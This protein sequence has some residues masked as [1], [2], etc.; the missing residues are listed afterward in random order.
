MPKDFHLAD[1]NWGELRELFQELEFTKWLKELDSSD[2]LLVEEPKSAEVEQQYETVLTL[3][4]WSSWL[5]QLQD[6]AVFAFDTETTSIDPME[7]E[8][9]GFSVS[10]QA[11]ERPYVPLAHDYPDAPQQCNRE[12]VLQ[13]LAGILNDANKTCVGHNLKY[14]LHV[15]RHQEIPVANRL[16]DTMLASYIINPSARGHKLDN[17]VQSAFGHTMVAFEDVAG[18]GAKQVTFDQVDLNVA[19][20]YAAE[21]A[22]MT[23]RLYHH[24]CPLIEAKPNHRLFHEVDLPLMQVLLNMEH[25]GVNIDAGMLVQQSNELANKLDHL[26]KEI[27]ESAEEEF[28]V[29][30]TKQLRAVLFDKLQLPIIKKTP[31][32]QP[33]TSEEVLQELALT[34]VLP[35]KILEFRSSQK[36][37]S[38][39]TDKLPLQIN[40]QTGRIHQL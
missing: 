23:L 13:Q 4:Q 40:P 33:S 39:Y 20:H 3:E 5:K 18:T 7:A 31:K 19:G 14:D 21:D 16:W 1:P 11:E 26:Q 6:A 38:T 32:G 28:N 22:D 10:T 34:Y 15:L 24:L 27:Y 9:V 36:L 17:L 8:L 29:A 35:K 30:S 12:V 37:K 2:N 25:E